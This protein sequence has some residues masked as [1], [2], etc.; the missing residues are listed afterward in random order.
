MG[1]IPVGGAK[2]DEQM[3]EHL[4]ISFIISTKKGIEESGSE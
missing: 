4:L 2:R 3:R 1:S